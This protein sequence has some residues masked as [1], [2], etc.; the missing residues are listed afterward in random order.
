VSSVPPVA[1]KYSLAPIST[2]EDP[3][4]TCTTPDPK[5]L[6]KMIVPAV[7]LMPASLPAVVVVPIPIEVEVILLL[8]T[9]ILPAVTEPSDR[10]LR[11]VFD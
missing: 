11:V 7:V 3:L 2:Q 10:F 8:P 9:V 1:S 5:E 4:K 6:L